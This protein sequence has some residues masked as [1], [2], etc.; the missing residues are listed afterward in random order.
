[1]KI[2]SKIQNVVIVLV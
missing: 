1:V 2:N